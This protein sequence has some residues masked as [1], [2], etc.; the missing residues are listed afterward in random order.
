MLADAARFVIEQELV[1]ARVEGHDEV[2]DNGWHLHF[3]ELCDFRDQRRHGDR[4]S[5]CQLG[6]FLFEPVRN[7]TVGGEA[8][9]PFDAMVV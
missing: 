2:G 5:F 3:D 9:S 7:R 1:V 4:R 6:N 8:L